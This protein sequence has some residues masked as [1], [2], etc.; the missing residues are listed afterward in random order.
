MQHTGGY[1]LGFF[2]FHP[3]S[4]RRRVVKL[5][6]RLIALARGRSQAIVDSTDPGEG[7]VI[8]SGYTTE[9][10]ETLPVSRRIQKQL[11]SISP[12]QREE[13]RLAHFRDGEV[14]AFTQWEYTDGA[15]I[16]PTPFLIQGAPYTITVEGFVAG[17]ANLRI[18]N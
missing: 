2:N 9:Y 8:L 1:A 4:G 7:Y 15:H 17:G 12:P 16:E 6:D 14:V 10:I 5:R 3:G 13:Q 18:Q 11:K